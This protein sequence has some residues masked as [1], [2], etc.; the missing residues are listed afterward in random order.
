MTSEHKS[1][2]NCLHGN[3]AVLALPE[4]INHEYIHNAVQH[5]SAA[6]ATKVTPAELKEKEIDTFCRFLDE[7]LSLTDLSFYL[8]ARN[9][10]NESRSLLLKVG[11]IPFKC[12]NVRWT[13]SW[14]GR[15]ASTGSR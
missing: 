5:Y 1:D 9:V 3:R 8:K 15:C 12:I 7:D 2:R 13:P 4:F 11:L 14:T 6:S 10:L